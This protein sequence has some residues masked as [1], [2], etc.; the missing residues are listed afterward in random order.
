MSSAE[1][2]P[3]PGTRVCPA[4]FGEIIT[5]HLERHVPLPA[6]FRDLLARSVLRHLDSQILIEDPFLAFASPPPAAAQIEIPAF[7]VL[8]AV[9]DTLAQVREE[10]L[11]PHLYRLTGLFGHIML[12][13]S[14][15]PEQ[16]AAVRE[17]VAQGRGGAFFMTDRGGPALQQWHS[18][19]EVE[20][21]AWHVSLDKIWTIGAV[22]CEFA[23]VVVSRQGSMAPVALLL[24]PEQCVPLHRQASGLPYFAGRVQLGSCRGAFVGS[25]A[26][27]LTRGG[28]IAVKQFLTIVRPRLVLALMA[29][30]DWLLVQGR[31]HISPAH[32]EAIDCLRELCGAISRAKFYTRHSEDEVMA[33]KFASNTLLLDCVENGEVPDAMDARDMLAMTKMEGSSYRCFYEIYMR[34]RGRRQ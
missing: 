13:L 3:T 17:W 15:T 32:R 27:A 22:D 7:P 11:G 20:G 33:L 30:L 28:L 10:G 16:V 12:S 21:D 24:G 8:H 23:I 25:P 5:H 31:L 34:N 19:L 1:A 2:L 14:G 4:S 18:R 29:H 9:A 26:M 6:A